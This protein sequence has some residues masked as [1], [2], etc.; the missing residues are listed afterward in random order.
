MLESTPKLSF[1]FS[2]LNHLNESSTKCGSIQRL[3]T[4]IQHR[5]SEK[6]RATGILLLKYILVQF[7]TAFRKCQHPCFIER[8]D[9]TTRRMLHTFI[10]AAESLC[11]VTNAKE[12]NLKDA[13]DDEKSE[14]RYG[15]N[16]ESNETRNQ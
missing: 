1:F 11:F 14:R 13:C 5:F 2:L 8:G 4:E 3:R 16:M 12:V 9:V 10:V 15:V 7:F 6:S